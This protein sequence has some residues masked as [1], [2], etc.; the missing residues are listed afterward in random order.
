[1]RSFHPH[2]ML[3]K[4]RPSLLLRVDPQS[5]AESLAQGWIFWN[6]SF[7]ALSPQHWRLH[8]GHFPVHCDLGLLWPY[9]YFAFICLIH[10]FIQ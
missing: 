8:H 2:V 10:A 5:V 7:Q 3:K 9:F 4:S 6:D 1:M